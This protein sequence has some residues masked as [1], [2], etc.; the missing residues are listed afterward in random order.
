MRES[1]LRLEEPE[2]PRQRVTRRGRDKICSHRGRASYCG[3]G[4]RADTLSDYRLRYGPTCGRLS[5]Y[6]PETQPSSWPKTSGTHCPEHEAIPVADWTIACGWSDCQTLYP[7][8]YVGRMYCAHISSSSSSSNQQRPAAAS[9]QQPA[10]PA[11]QS[12]PVP[13]GRL[14]LCAPHCHGLP[15]F[16]TSH[17]RQAK[18]DLSVVFWGN[19]RP[20]FPNPF[21]PF[22]PHDTLESLLT[23]FGALSGSHFR[24]KLKLK[25]AAQGPGVFAL[26]RQRY[27]SDLSPTVSL[28]L[29]TPPAP[30]PHSPSTHRRPHLRIRGMLCPP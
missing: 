23:T 14:R 12:R 8:P 13:Y 6:R 9:S 4:S 5:D 10:G 22:P 11:H 19:L 27:S 17:T 30:S 1:W 25:S 24:G 29:S 3:L 18:L 28:R 26:C 20:T 16:P 21:Q 7:E 15:D 2:G